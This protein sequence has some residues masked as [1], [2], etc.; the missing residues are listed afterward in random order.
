MKSIN[1]Y[2][3]TIFNNIN[4]QPNR[5]KK[6]KKIFIFYILFDFIIKIYYMIYLI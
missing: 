6:F 4:Y 2:T 5:W 3:A 1:F